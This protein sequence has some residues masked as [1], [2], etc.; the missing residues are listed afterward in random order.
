MIKIQFRE[1][2][3]DKQSSLLQW[4]INI[5]N[6][7]MIKPIK[8]LSQN[9][10]VNP[11]IIRDVVKSVERNGSLVEVGSGL[12][13]LSY[14][15]SRKVRDLKAFFEIDIRLAEISLNLID[16]GIVV[17]SDALLHEWRFKQ[18][19]STVPYHLTSS[20]VIKTAR[21]N[22]IEK[23]VLVL[24]REVVDRILAKPGTSNYGRLT[25]I[26]NL[27]FDAEPGPSYPPS[28]FYPEPDVYSRMIILRR[29]RLY[30]KVMSYLEDITRKIFSEKRKRVGKV[31]SSKLG[32]NEDDIRKLG[33]D[34]MKRIY[35][36]SEIEILRV[37]EEL[38]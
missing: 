28:F 33:I 4:T 21:S 18:L 6:A 16:D 30:D 25:I 10:V 15:L 3:L 19:V 26:V 38:L 20:I 13:T 22:E 12:G 9:F 32:L 31:F 34:P 23:A 7:N 8:K 24:Q 1:P 11:I 27:L 17:N 35:E 2:P 37:T 14:F 29:R 36:L 5:L